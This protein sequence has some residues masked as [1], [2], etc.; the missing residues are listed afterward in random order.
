[1]NRTV[2]AVLMLIFGLLGLFM[3]ACGAYFTVG[4]L[5]SRHDAYTGAMLVVAVP[6]LAIGALLLWFIRTKYG[7]W[8]VAGVAT[9]IPPPPPPE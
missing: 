8:R 3:T 7:A 4:G 9:T 1:M 6:S 5:V 2:A